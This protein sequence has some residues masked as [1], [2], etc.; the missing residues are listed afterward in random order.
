MLEKLRKIL[1]GLLVYGLILAPG[2]AAQESL[3]SWRGPQAPAALR[4]D[5]WTF[6]E[7]KAQVLRTPNYSIYTT[8][9]DDEVKELL[10]QVMEGALQMYRQIAPDV[11]L[12]DRPM[13]CFIFRWR[14]E[15]DRYTQRYAG[16]DAQVYLQIRSGGYTIQDR[17]VAYY[18]GRLA[19]FSVAAHEGWHQYASRHFIGRLPPFLEEGLACMFETIS[20]RDRLPRWNLAVNPTR[21]LMLRHAVEANNLWPLEQL[22]AMHAG[23]IVGES[24]DRIDAFYAESWAFARFLWEGE[25][26]KYRPAL[27]KWIAETAAGTVYDPTRSHS[28]AAAPWNRRAVRPMLEHYLG[29]DVQTVDAAFRAYMKKIAQED[30]GVWQS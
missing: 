12:T 30:P 15:W 24:N 20:W 19:T 1:G 9:Q 13:D 14:S 23:D 25:G 18:I 26:G 29:E 21:A 5:D 22:C 28:R 4:V 3:S 11:A 7:Q 27:A 6:G 2:C 8:I 17:S 10:P 16:S